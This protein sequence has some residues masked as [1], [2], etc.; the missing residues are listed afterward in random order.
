MNTVTPVVVLACLCLLMRWLRLRTLGGAA[1]L[2]IGLYLLVIFE[3]LPLVTGL[4][5]G[6]LTVRGVITGA[7]DW[8]TMVLHTA[9]VVLAFIGTAEA[10]HLVLSF[11]LVSTFRDIREHAAAFNVSE[12]RPYA[13]WIRANLW[14]FV[15]G[16]GLCQ[17]FLFAAALVGVV[18]TRRGSQ[19]AADPL[20]VTALSLVAV[21]ITV[22]LIGINRGE[23]TRLWIFLSCLFQIP[24]AWVCARLGT[25]AAIGIVTATSIVQAAIGTGVVGFVVP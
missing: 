20:A 25:P 3:P 14:E 18:A 5:F 22:D 21:L 24:A 12:G 13:V 23:V 9:V 4:L 1:L 7:M 10:A 17:V 11:D 8:H 2:G 19:L 16:T 6:A 15:L